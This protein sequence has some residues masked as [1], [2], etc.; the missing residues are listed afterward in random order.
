MKFFDYK[1][2]I[3]LGLAIAFYFMYREQ[4][5]LFM[6]MDNYNDKL[7]L[8]NSKIDVLEDSIEF[9][10][11]KEKDKNNKINL[12]ILKNQLDYINNS[13]NISHNSKKMILPVV[14]ESE[15]HVAIY[16]NDGEIYD[17]DI[18]N[19]I[20][21][22][23]TFDKNL[24]I[25]F[26]Y[27]ENKNVDSDKSDKSTKSTKS[28]KSIKSIKSTKSNKSNI[29]NINLVNPNHDNNLDVISNLDNNLVNSNHDNNLD[30][31]SNLDN[32]LDVNSNLDTSIVNSN[33]DNN[34]DVNSNLDTNLVNDTCIVNSNTFNDLD[35]LKLQELK[36]LALKLNIDI[37][38]TVKG[39]LKPKLKNELIDNIK[40]HK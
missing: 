20:L 40:K 36:E 22:S 37:N 30:V 32:N 16:S 8:I 31:N 27:Q 11:N 39:N 28:T 33:H 1:I 35:K 13:R 26:N 7:K 17:N 34:L 12:D 29:Y 14:S 10:N 15:K 2:L 38:K 21:E 18:D 9:I 25:N 19:S 5:S 6:R 3:L 4:Q 23:S 24:K